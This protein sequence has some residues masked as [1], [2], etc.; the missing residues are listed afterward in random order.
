[1]PKPRFLHASRTPIALGRRFHQIAR[2][3]LSEVQ[4]PLGLRP[5]EFGVLI[6]L[7]DWP[8]QDQ[9][10]LGERMALDRTTTSALVGRLEQQGLIERAVNNEDRRARVLRLTAAGRR[11]HDAHRPDADAAQLAMLR[12]LSAAERRTLFELLDRVIA[13][14]EAYVRPGAGRKR[15]V[16]GVAVKV[17]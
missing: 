6:R 5:L 17:G 7:H 14:N 3:R 4:E 16:R 8:G 13:A 2:A 11:L 12:C 9:N 10:T 1:M 15:P